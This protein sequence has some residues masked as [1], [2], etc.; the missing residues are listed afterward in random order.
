VTY[1]RRID[2]V[3]R[4]R[5]G[6]FRDA[7]IPEPVDGKRWLRFPCPFCGGDRAAI[8]YDVGIFEC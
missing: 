7:G 6:T 4:S 2:D 8:S 1:M 3:L 5:L